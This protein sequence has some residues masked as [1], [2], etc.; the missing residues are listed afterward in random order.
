MKAQA[1]SNKKAQQ[2]GIRQPRRTVAFAIVLLGLALVA[3]ALWGIWPD[4]QD[5]LEAR[6]EY[7]GLREEFT[8]PMDMSHLSDINPDFVAWIMIPGTRVSY[9]VVQGAD[10]AKYLQTTFLGKHNPA[11]AIF[12][13]YRIM[14]PFVA[15]VNMIYG[16]NMRDGSM[17]AALNGYLDTGFLS[18]HSE[19]IVYTLGGEV[20]HYQI[21]EARRISAQDPVFSL[22]FNDPDSL[23]HFDIPD[24]LVA[25]AENDTV[26]FVDTADFAG[27]GDENILVLSTCSDGQS[28]IDRNN[29]R[30]VVFAVR[31]N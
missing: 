18:E 12:M 4:W 16:H 11:G 3:V 13:D 24:K 9:P 21:F 26:G 5:D 8:P 6:R 1:D 25:I 22:D 14:A 7:A 15:P 30:V 28:N 27:K 23:K 19:V 29:A 17:F 20:L 31:L 2:S 10:N